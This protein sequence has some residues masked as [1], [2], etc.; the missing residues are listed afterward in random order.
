MAKFKLGNVKGQKG[1]KGDQGDKGNAATVKIG[2]VT[3]VDST[4]PASVT[5]SGTTNDA[6]LDFNIPKGDPGFDLQQYIENFYALRRTGKVYQT[7]LWKFATNQSSTGEKLLD[8][9]GLVFEPSTDTTE[10]QDDYLNGKHPMFEWVNVNYKRNSKGAPYPVAIEGTEDY[11]DDGSIDVGTMQMSFY[12][13]WDTSN[14]EYDLITISDMPHP[15]LGLKPWSE[16]NDG[17]NG[18]LPWCI[19][20][21]YFSGLGTDGLLRS[22]PNSKPELYQSHN[23]IITNY[24]KKGEGYWGAGSEANVF[25]IIFNVIKGATKNSQSLYKGCVDYNYQYSAS[26]ERSTNETYFPVTTTQ[27]ANLV[28]GSTV[29][30]GYAGNNNGSLNTDRGVGTM[31]QYA[32]LARI[33][34]IE[35]IDSSNSAVYLDIETGFNTT[36]VALTDSLSSPIYLSTMEWYSGS[37]D[38]VI[39]RHDG[40]YISNTSGKCPYRV[41][42]REYAI[43]GWFVASDTVMDFQSD[44]S[45]NVYVAPR[46]V[47]HSSSDF[48]IRSTYTLVGNIPANGNGSDFYIGDI[49]VNFELGVEY[50]SAVGSSDSTGWGDYCWT[51]GASTSGTREFLLGGDLWNGSNAGSVFL[52]ARCGLGRG[53]WL[54]CARD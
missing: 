30:V 6:I 22:F 21:K 41:Q 31:H 24:Q 25:Q 4:E 1:D 16:C 54:F 11:K 2:T 7:K 39:G 43:G 9:A 32:N 18:V 27:A 38:K 34:K 40:S 28:V 5:N 3:R 13:K 19:G 47:V 8:N 20:S 33:T 26:I 49:A 52:H 37:T 14:A 17:S 45:K 23:N 35:A 12:G 29:S 48:T 46:G 36:P 42:G 10:G 51:G 53:Y 44:Y 15:E 50:P